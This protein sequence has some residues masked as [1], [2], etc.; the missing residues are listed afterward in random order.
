[1][2]GTCAK[3]S[4]HACN[5][6]IQNIKGNKGLDGTGK[7]AAVDTVG[8]SA[9]QVVLSQTQRNGH[10]LV[11]L[12]AGRDDILDRFVAGMDS[13]LGEGACHV[14]SIRPQGGVQAV[15]AEV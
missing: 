14:L 10:I 1:M 3:D 11:G 4:I 5:K 13:V 9:L 15:P 2:A 7:T 6:G 12:I 8:A